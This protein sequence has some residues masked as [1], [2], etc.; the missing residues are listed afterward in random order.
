MAQGCLLYYITD[1]TQFA[2]DEPSRR[3]ALLA[4]I[5]DAASAGVDYIQLREKDVST[6]ELESLA[7][8]AVHAI[9]TVRALATSDQR[10][11]LCD[12]SATANTFPIRRAR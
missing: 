2:G 6:R 12:A 8:D 5:A 4:K 9:R 3:S 7:R 10:P 1:R 11:F